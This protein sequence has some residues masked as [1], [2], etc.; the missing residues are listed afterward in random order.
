MKKTLKTAFLATIPIMLGYLSVGIAF[1]LLFQKSGYNFIWA[2][3]MS[4][5]VYAGSMQFVAIKLLTG[6]TVIYMLIVQA[7]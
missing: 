5:T 2:I 4:S 7:I 6:G 1:G 3:L